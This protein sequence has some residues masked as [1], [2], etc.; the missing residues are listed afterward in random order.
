MEGGARPDHSTVS[1][2]A[3]FASGGP[4]VS[5]PTRKR[6]R[7]TAEAQEQYAAELEVFCQTILQIRSTLGFAATARGYCYY[8]EGHG[9]ITKAQFDAAQKLIGDC[10]KDGSLSYDICATDETREATGLERLDDDVEDE[11]N[12]AVHACRNWHHDYTP[13]S[14]WDDQDIYI[15]IA[16]EKGDLRNLFAPVCERFRIPITNMK[17][18]ADINC[19]VEMMKRFADM[20]DQGKSCVLLICGDHDPGGLHISKFMRDN[21]QELAI[22]AEWEPDDLEIVRFGLNRDFIDRHG[23]MWIDNLITS[24]GADLASPRH[25]DHHK[26]YVQDYLRE[27]SARKVEA[28]ALMADPAAARQLCLDAILQYLTA[29]APEQYQD[30]LEGHREEL[31]ARIAEL[32][33]DAAE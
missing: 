23:L 5:L 12:R 25:P 28:N 24:S 15:E 18:W 32:M 22:P 3:R 8:L 4:V 10:R 26:Q 13:F 7:Q 1:R 21:L 6:G 33:A 2:P 11:A 30:R 9:E 14:F 17:G 20:E 16:V 31:R 29:D 19:R 27:H